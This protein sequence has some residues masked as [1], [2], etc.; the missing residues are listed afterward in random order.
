[1]GFIF[2]ASSLPSCKALLHFFCEFANGVVDLLNLRILDCAFELC[3]ISIVNEKILLLGYG[4]RSL[5]S[6]I[7]DRLDGMLSSMLCIQGSNGSVCNIFLVVS[8]F[9]RMFLLYCCG[10]L[11]SF[12]FLVRDTII[13]LMI[14]NQHLNIFFCLLCFILGN[15]T[16]IFCFSWPSLIVFTQDII[17]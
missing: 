15:S 5:C 12:C 11:I 2:V 17:C 16:V 4:F 9:R 7:E 14:V 10:W 13:S 8:H 3:L 1:M 6:Q